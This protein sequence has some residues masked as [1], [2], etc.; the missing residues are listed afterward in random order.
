MGSTRLPGKVSKLILGKTMLAHQIERVR[1]ARL[2]DKIVV[3]TTTKSED[4]PIAS[5]AYEAGAGCFRGSELDVLDRYYQAAKEAHADIVIRITGDCPLSDP[6]VIDETIEYFL[7]NI[8]DVDYTSK[9]TNYPEGLDMEIFSFGSLEHAW[10]KAVKPSEREHVT[11]YIYNH[12]EIFRVRTWRNGE[13][14]FSTMHWS[15]DTPDDFIFVTK[16]FE[17]LYSVDPSFSKNDVI[18][19]LSEKPELLTIN[20]GGTGYEGYAKSLKEDDMFFQQ[21]QVTYEEIVDFEPEA[22]IVF[23]GGIIASGE[24]EGI[25]WRTTTYDD[26]DAFG[27]L[28]GRD[29]VEAAAVLAKKYPNPYLVT[30]SHRLGYVA[31]SLAQVYAEELIALGVAQERIV[32][33]EYSS[34]TQTA[35][36]AVIGLAQKREW[37]RLLLLSSEFHLPRIAAFYEKKKSD[38]AVKLIS[39]ESI[40]STVEPTS[41]DRF[42]MIRKTPAY[43]LRLESERRG[44][45]ALEKGIYREAPAQDKKER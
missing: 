25:H 6:S 43:Q 31:P 23:S 45:I 42:A 26:S 39:S 3:A 35:V 12:P 8:A 30:T 32:Q 29:R 41:A 38:I 16:I 19:L 28:G 24:D 22:I 4:D 11:P 44:I 9:P 33:E 34:S 13:E 10:K 36:D 7:K 40:L 18:N 14:D 5:M 15:V 17:A 21:R 1:H 20:A 27:T 37:K 2:I